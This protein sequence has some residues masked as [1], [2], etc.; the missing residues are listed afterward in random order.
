MAVTVLTPAPTRLSD[1]CR[2]PQRCRGQAL[3]YTLLVSFTQRTPR[4]AFSQTARGPT[5]DTDVLFG[6]GR[7]F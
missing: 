1:A 5:A 4:R 7:V 3:F 6:L 2:T